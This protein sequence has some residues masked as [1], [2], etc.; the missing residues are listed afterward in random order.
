MVLATTNTSTTKD[1]RSRAIRNLMIYSGVPGKQQ[2]QQPHQQQRI[3][4]ESVGGWG[5][6]NEISQ[7]TAQLQA[8]V[9]VTNLSRNYKK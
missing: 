4:I 2:R 5:G 6:R 1:N 8:Q 3:I 7:V 9:E